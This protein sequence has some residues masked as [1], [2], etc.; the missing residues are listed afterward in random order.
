MHPK[1]KRVVVTV[2]EKVRALRRI[3]LGESPQQLALELGV[4]RQTISDWKR[5]RHEIEKFYVSSVERGSI[6]GRKTLKRS[7][8]QLLDEALFTW[9][10]RATRDNSPL[11]GTVLQRQA[12]KLNG[13]LGGDVSFT[14]SKGW[15]NRWKER[16]GVSLPVRPPVLGQDEFIRSLSGDNW[17]PSQIFNVGETSLCFKMLPEK[18]LPTRPDDV[19]DVRRDKVTLLLCTNASA[20]LRLPIVGK[21]PLNEWWFYHQFVP[22]VKKYLVE[23][24][25][26]EKAVLFLDDSL[27]NLEELTI[28]NIFVKYLPPEMS[29][30]IRHKNHLIIETFKRHYRKTLVTTILERGESKGGAMGILKELKLE[31]VFGMIADA[32]DGV[33]RSILISSWEKLWPGL[34]TAVLHDDV[35]HHDVP[36][37]SEFVT[38]LKGLGGA[39]E[40]TEA[41]VVRWMSCEDEF[42][43]H[44]QE[45]SSPENTT[46]GASAY[47]NQTFAGD[48]SQ[49]EPSSSKN[50]KQ[51]SSYYYSTTTDEEIEVPCS[52]AYIKQENAFVSDTQHA[53]AKFMLDNLI[54]YFEKQ[55]DTSD[56][57]LMTLK[58]LRDRTANKV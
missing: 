46:Q 5:N 22:A 25:L 19:E 27:P 45:P 58:R 36:A 31:D 23:E 12:L 3:D 49:E 34:S 50:I 14:A 55:E 20:N 53:D 39:A 4:G 18:V 15:L 1:R 56:V 6:S 47:V 32:W 21:S 11:S 7:N 2:E 40:L 17:H 48:D 8:Y 29:C 51:E 41:D 44:P 42:L 13:E 43:C 16:H 30:H 28:D 9:F 38:L 54:V 57:E 24:G 10:V 33:S 52:P 35:E 26:E 37:D